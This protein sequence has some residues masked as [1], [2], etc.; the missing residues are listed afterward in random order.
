M[1]FQVTTTTEN[2]LSV[3]KATR[4]VATVRERLE[5]EQRAEERR[6]AQAERDDPATK[7]DAELKMAEA[8]LVEALEEV[9]EERPGACAR[10]MGKALRQSS[11]RVAY[12][13]FVCMVEGYEE[14]RKGEEPYPPRIRFFQVFPNMKW[15]LRGRPETL[16]DL[17]A[18]FPRALSAFNLRADLW[19]GA[20]WM[21]DR[22]EAMSYAL[23][24]ERDRG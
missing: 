6:R 22:F 1:G 4:A 19:S 8:A 14:A 20:N 12:G 24:L 5:S 21:N 9:R 18:F 13:I 11:L 10:A 15:Y 2:R 3:E 23:I 7:R 17:Q 16:G